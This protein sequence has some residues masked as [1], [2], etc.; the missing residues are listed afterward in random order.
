MN[1]FCGNQDMEP[2]KIAL[3]GKNRNEQSKSI[4]PTNIEKQQEQFSNETL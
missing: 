4:N 1:I 3:S 2:K